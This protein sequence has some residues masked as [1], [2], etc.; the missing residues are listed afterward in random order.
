MLAIVWPSTLFVTC[1][2][3]IDVG[4]SFNA[5][6]GRRPPRSDLG[7]DFICRAGRQF[8]RASRHY[9][10]LLNTASGGKACIICSEDYRRLC[11]RDTQL[12]DHVFRLEV[13]S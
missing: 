13:S 12:A 4:C 1:V 11:M 9:N 7:P 2:S 6:A 8:V 5:T 3:P 10:G